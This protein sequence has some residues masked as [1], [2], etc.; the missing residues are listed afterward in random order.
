MASCGIWATRQ[1]LMGIA[2][3]GDGV[4]HGYVARRNDS[5]RWDLVSRIEAEHGLDCLFV[6]TQALLATDSLPRM[7]ARRGSPVRIAPD[8]LVGFACQIRGTGR[9]SPKSLADLLARMPL[10]P[11][12]AQRLMRLELQLP[13]L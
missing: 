4:A 8:E 3:D 9:A 2:I 12:F 13:L 11:P 10:C 7:A 1:R 5:E 6:V